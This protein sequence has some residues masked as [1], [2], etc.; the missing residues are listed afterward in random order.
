MIVFLCCT[1]Q[2]QNATSFATFEGYAGAHWPKETASVANR[3]ANS[4][5]W[6]GLEHAAWPFGGE[7]NGTLLVWESR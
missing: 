6:P 2:L 4:V 3:S 1:V 5:P 7:P